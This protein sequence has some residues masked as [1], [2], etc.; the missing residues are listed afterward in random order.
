MK[1]RLLPWLI[2]C[3]GLVS[4]LPAQS[5]PPDRNY[6]NAGKDG[7]LRPPMVA[8]F[9]PDH[10][11]PSPMHQPPMMMDIGELK[12]VLNE[13]G[14]NKATLEKTV[15]IARNF[16]AQLDGRLIKVQREELNIREELLK[17]KPDL[18]VIQ[19]YINKKTQIFAEIEFSQIKRDVEI[20]SLLTRDEYDRLKSAMMKK[21]KQMN[22][23]AE[24]NAGYPKS[25][26]PDKSR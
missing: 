16:L 3:T 13:I 20:K 23:F 9:G 26:K 5:A 11:S 24:K 7:A 2:L 21:M 17:D 19:G 10:R 4:F 8:P 14:V 12:A 1:R 22:P 15:D 25:D 6:D 18:T